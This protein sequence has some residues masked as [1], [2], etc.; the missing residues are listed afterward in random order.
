MT[1][2]P[3]IIGFLGRALSFEL[4]AVQQYLSVS[5]LMQ[6]KG[7]INE[8]EKFRTEA[9]EEMNHVE[10]II[11][12]LI[13]L[14]CAPSAS[15]LRPTKLQGSLLQVLKNTSEM[16]KEAVQL[17]EHAV[18]YCDKQ[19]DVE[20]KYFFKILLK[21]EQEHHLEMEALVQSISNCVD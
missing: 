15:Q 6:T 12:R 5:K 19:N 4:S 18:D 20:N 10:R 3:V 8:A 9:Q 7:L 16:E 11:A 14:G 13:G 21:E 1:L 2:D 17:Y